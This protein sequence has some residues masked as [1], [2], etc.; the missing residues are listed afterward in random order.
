MQIAIIGLGY[1][2][3]NMVRNFS[4]N[5]AV[6]KVWCC[7]K[8]QKKLEKIKQQYH[9]VETANNSEII[10]SNPDIKAVVI[11]TP[12]NSHFE[13]AKKALLAGKHVLVEKP[14]TASVSE[15][16]ELISL[17]NTLGLVC[18]VDHTFLYTSAVGKTK[19]LI[20]SGEIGDLYYF[21]SVR[22][23]LGLFQPDCN[24]VWDLAPHDFSIMLYLIDRK[25]I[26][27]QAMGSD[28]IGNGF[29][30]VAYVHVDF[31]E[32]LIAHFHV[33]WL[34]PVKIR[35]TLIAGTKKMIVYDDMNQ[36]EK[37]KVYESGIEVKSEEAKYQT[38]INYRSGNVF[39]PL[40]NNTEALKELVADFLNSI[41]FGVEPRSSKYLGLEVVRLLEAAQQAIKTGKKVML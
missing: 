28:H 26:S 31:G 30:D 5:P 33:N 23:N 29:E 4:T 21:D 35:Q 13:L 8:D 16:E 18:M 39:S 25:P 38:L 12:L 9:D 19:E 14:F 22:V 41:E 1:W 15:A 37:I 34:S 7:D 17:S 36:S 24:V 2:G 32:N 6:K 27:V 10:F 11:V 20:S 3:P 40:L